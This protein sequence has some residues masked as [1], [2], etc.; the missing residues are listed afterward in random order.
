MYFIY[1]SQ[2]RE[3]SFELEF[4]IIGAEFT[5]EFEEGYFDDEEQQEIKNY[6]DGLSKCIAIDKSYVECKANRRNSVFMIEDGWNSLRDMLIDTEY[7]RYL[8][9]KNHENL[10]EAFVTMARCYMYECVSLKTDNYSHIDISMSDKPFD[11]IIC[12]D[13]SN[14][15]KNYAGKWQDW[16]FDENGNYI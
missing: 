14:D 5:V 16:E 9:P 3:N 6:I 11:I 13:K 4:M 2:I 10:I 15:W 7:G 8:H 12:K 1:M